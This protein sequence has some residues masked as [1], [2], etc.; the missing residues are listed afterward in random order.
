[1]RHLGTAG[2]A[3]NHVVLADRVALVAEPQLAFALDGEEHLFFAMMAMEGALNLAGR[4]D[5]E[6]VAE[7]LGSD[8]V[9]DLATARR[10]AAVLLYVVERDLIKVQDGLHRV[11]LP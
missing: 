4:Q 5:G 2:R 1:M 9:A 10:I 6:I 8:V 11:A 7:V 3:R